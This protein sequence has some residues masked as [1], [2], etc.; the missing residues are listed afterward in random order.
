[1]S[2]KGA[3]P[4]VANRKRS[5]KKRTA[6]LLNTIVRNEAGDMIAFVRHGATADELRAVASAVRKL[7]A[8]Q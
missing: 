7:R 6:P 5:P 2:G 4:F 3:Q 8:N 1:M